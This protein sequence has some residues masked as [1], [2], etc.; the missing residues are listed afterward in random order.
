MRIVIVYKFEG[1]G[2]EVELGRRKFV[3]EGCREGNCEFGS[4]D[5]VSLRRC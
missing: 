4:S 5:I 2:E 3:V 1:W